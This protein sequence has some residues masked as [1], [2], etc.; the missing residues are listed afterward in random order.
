MATWLD[1]RHSRSPA[2][3]TEGHLKSP[4][5]NFSFLSSLLPGIATAHVHL[6]GPVTR[7]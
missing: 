4:P 7:G 2:L 3:H 5:T 1:G 6:V